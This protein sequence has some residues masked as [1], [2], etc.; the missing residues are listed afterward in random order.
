MFDHSL[1]DGI[2]PTIHVTLTKQKDKVSGMAKVVYVVGNETY[3]LSTKF[4][5][6]EYD[7]RSLLCSH[8]RIIEG[9]DVEVSEEDYEGYWFPYFKFFGE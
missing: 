9:T 8:E 4:D 5:Y 1:L 2:E 3:S 6:S 7:R